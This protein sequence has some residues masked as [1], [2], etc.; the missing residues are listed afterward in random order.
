MREVELLDLP[1][2]T[3]ATIPAS[4]PAV[5]PMQMLQI[6][7]DKGADIDQLTK[8]M[9]LSERWEATEARKAFVAAMTQFKANPPTILKAKHVSFETNTGGY[10][11]YFHATLADVC[12]A[13]TKALADV[14]ISHRW[15]VQQEGGGIS[16]TCLLTHERGHSESTTMTAMADTSGKKNSIQAVASTVTYLQRYTLLAATGLSTRDMVDND[17]RGDPETLGPGQIAD[18]EAMIT[19]VGADRAKFLQFCRVERLEEIN[20]DRYS[21]CIAALEAKRRA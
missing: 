20:V 9:D 11:E 15:S 19:E 2:G 1:K 21:A 3:V 13:A 7:V 16:V 8:L 5:T 17:G 12:D 18:L 4:L 14:G 10:T 6:A